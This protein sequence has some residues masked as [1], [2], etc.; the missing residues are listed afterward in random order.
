MKAVIYDSELTKKQMWHIPVVLAENRMFQMK[1]FIC[2][3]LVLCKPWGHTRTANIRHFSTRTHCKVMAPNS[4]HTSGV[5]TIKYL[6]TSAFRLLSPFIHR[7][8]LRGSA[9]NNR[10][11]PDLSGPTSHFWTYLPVNPHS[12]LH[13]QIYCVPTVST[14]TL[15]QASN[16]GLA[17]LPGTTACPIVRI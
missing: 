12:P 1:L 9:K 11:K 15:T 5:I 13:Q 16:R 17:V 4:P 10:Q 14:E 7:G 2:L 3:Q 8:S 6:G